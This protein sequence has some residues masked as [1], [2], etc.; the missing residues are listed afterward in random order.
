MTS[1]R[2]YLTCGAGA[3]KATPQHRGHKMGPMRL[4]DR[5]YIT[6]LHF[7]PNRFTMPASHYLIFTGWILFLLPNQQRQKIE[8]IGC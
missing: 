7:A 3:V 8:V 4:S 1:D 2:P 6:Y 5:P